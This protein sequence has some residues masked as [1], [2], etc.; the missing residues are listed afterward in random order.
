MQLLGYENN[1][2]LSILAQ[3][4]GDACDVHN[5]HV[6]CRGLYLFKKFQNSAKNAWGKLSKNIRFKN[7]R[8]KCHHDLNG[9]PFIHGHVNGYPFLNG[10]A[11]STGY[12]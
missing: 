10:G 8:H 3:I 6:T 5:L 7:G 9:Y 1:F 4:K 2:Q 12:C 11:E